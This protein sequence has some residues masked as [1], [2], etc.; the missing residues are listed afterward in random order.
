MIWRRDEGKAMENKARK[1][2]KRRRG[3]IAERDKGKS[4]C[5]LRSGGG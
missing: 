4:R 3:S 1:K 2:K 5:G